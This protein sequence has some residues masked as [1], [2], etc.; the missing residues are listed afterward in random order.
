[1]KYHIYLVTQQ[2]LKMINLMHQFHYNVIL[3]ILYWIVSPFDYITCS[4][5]YT[6]NNALCSFAM[7]LL[8]HYGY[9]DVFIHCNSLCFIILEFHTTDIFGEINNIFE[10]SFIWFNESMRRANDRLSGFITSTI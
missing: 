8:L 9:A 6:Y 2:Q 1:M 3:Y 4:R 10:N 7:L 5:E